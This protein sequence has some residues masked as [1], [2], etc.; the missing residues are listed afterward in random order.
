MIGIR[1]ELRDARERVSFKCTKSEAWRNA[2][3]EYHLNGSSDDAMEINDCSG[4]QTLNSIRKN[5]S[6]RTMSR[7][8]EL[9]SAHEE[10]EQLAAKLTE[11]LAN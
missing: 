2:T 10:K 9:I 3:F 6:G 7:L 1:E 5:Y 4:V 11:L 8:R